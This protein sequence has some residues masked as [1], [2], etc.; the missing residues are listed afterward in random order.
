[1]DAGRL[2]EILDGGDA[3]ALA[4]LLGELP[5]ARRAAMVAAD[6]TEWPDHPLGASPLGYVAMLRYDTRTGRWRNVPHAADLAR[7]L[8]AAGAPVDGNPGDR[9]TPLITAASYGDAA[10]AGVLID[11]GADLHRRA[12]ADAGGVPNGTA[13]LHAAVF[14]MTDVVDVLMRAGA[15]AGSIEEAA[16]AGDIDAWLDQ[17]DR[18]DQPDQQQ[19]LRAMTMAADHQRIG[20]IRRL[21]EIGTPVDQADAVFGRNPLLVAAENGRPD[22][23]AMLLEL[24]A[25][26]T[27]RDHDGRTAIDLCRQARDTAADPAGHDATLA[28]LESATRYASRRSPGR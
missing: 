13:L 28:L 14:G 22:S 27:T 2:R 6:V 24:G 26:P 12:T 8:L 3:D 1:M 16:A 11:A 5:E 19:C 9:E 17:P 7:V 20:V 23:V 21:A 15:R 4:A 10:V 25:D 18:P